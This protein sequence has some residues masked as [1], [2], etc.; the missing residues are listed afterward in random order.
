MD[1]KR[2]TEILQILPYADLGNQVEFWLSAVK[3]H[4]KLEEKGKEILL[5]TAEF[6]DGI[7]WLE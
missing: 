5:K 2:E 4:Q 3:R 6:L 7:I 1:R